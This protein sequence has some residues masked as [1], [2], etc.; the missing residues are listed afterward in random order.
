V[1]QTLLGP[2]LYNALDAAEEVEDARHLELVIDVG[3]ALDAGHDAHV[4]KHG[5]VFR[6]GGD[7]RPDHLGQLADAALALREFLHEKKARGVGHRLDDLGQHFEAALR[8][9]IHRHPLQPFVIWHY[10]QIAKDMQ[11][12]NPAAIHREN[13]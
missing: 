9:L 10:N 13:T 1:G 6:H 11:T 3:P 7:V 8:F 5:Q 2:G 4:L 12:K